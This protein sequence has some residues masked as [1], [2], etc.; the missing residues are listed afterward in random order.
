[1]CAE[2]Q[3]PFDPECA[4]ESF[5]TPKTRNRDQPTTGGQ[6]RFLEVDWY[7]TDLLEFLYTTSRWRGKEERREQHQKT[8]AAY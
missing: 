4:H 5:E 8:V 2:I 7:F 1:M 6:V 3:Y